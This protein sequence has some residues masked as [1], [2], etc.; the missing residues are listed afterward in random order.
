MAKTYDL[1]VRARGETKDAERAMK[2]LQGTVKSAGEKMKRSGESMTKFVTLPILGAAAASVKLAS[3]AG[4]TASKMQVTFGKA[5]MAAVNKQLDAFAKATGAS[6]YELREQTTTIGA[7]LKPMELGAKQTQ[8]MSVSVAQLAT[9]LASF[10]NVPIDEA[11]DSLKSGLTGETEPLKK[12]G[13]LIN[14]NTLKQEGLRL[15]LIKGKEQMTEQEKVQARYSLILKQTSDAQ[16]D[17]ARTSGSFANQMKAAKNGLKD[18][19]VSM[20]NILLPYALKLVEGLRGVTTWFQNLSPHTQKVL[21]VVA[22]LAAALG[23]LLVGLGMVVSSASALVPLMVAMTGPVGLVIVGI[24]ALGVALVAAYLKSERFRDV[25]N[26]SFRSVMT[27]VQQLAAQVRL[28]LAAMSR[29]WDKHGADIMAVV[30]PYFRALGRF[31]GTW[32]ANVRDVISAALSLM[33]GDWSGAFGLLKGIA[34]R[35]L[36]LAADAVKAGGRLVVA[37]VKLIPKAVAALGEFFYNAGMKLGKRVVDA[38][39]DAIKGAAGRIGSA[40]KGAAS[41][42]LDKITFDVPGIGKSAK[43]KKKGNATAAGVSSMGQLFGSNV[44]IGQVLGYSSNAAG[45][46][47]S[48]STDASGVQSVTENKTVTAFLQQRV[49]DAQA[50]LAAKLSARKKALAQIKA[51]GTQ[52][53]KLKA[54]KAAAAKAKNKK[55]AAAKG[56]AMSKVL[57]QRSVLQDQV[58]NLNG[59][60]LSLGGQIE[61]DGEALVPPTVDNSETEANNARAAEN[62]RREALGLD[63]VETEEHLAEL[64]AIRAANGLA[65][66]ASV[67]DIGKAPTA[68]GPDRFDPATFN[69]LTPTS[70]SALAAAGDAAVHAFAGSGIN[71]TVNP[72]GADAEAIANRVAFILGSSRLRAGGAI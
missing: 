32:M 31:V 22:G 65:P 64:N 6:R 49:K 26:R 7:L 29:A 20:G 1:L 57:E 48:T 14:E 3:D 47:Y 36:G 4:E 67:S 62:L 72:N 50:Q 37:G 25:V 66:V 13:V 68:P 55:L 2:Q 70:T 40:A 28:T 12:F 46:A 39:V 11:L 41:D 60:I 63:S 16:G 35:S 33:R 21:V 23:P 61:S 56:A 54:E 58:E 45:Q 44:S 42:A 51:L 53:N 38:I 5:G 18:L 10:N 52:Y 59:E 24:A 9:D 15:G 71:I 30:G 8:S 43:G 17:A 19:G 27:G 69:P 34:S